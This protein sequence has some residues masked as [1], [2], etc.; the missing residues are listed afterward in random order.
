MN[1]LTEGQLIAFEELKQSDGWGIITDIVRDVIKQHC[2]LNEVNDE[3]DDKEY[4]IQCLAM[5]KAKAMF[6]QI[7]SE[8]DNIGKEIEHLKKDYS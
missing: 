1:K 4:K 3:L 8:V 2:N 5:K 6:K 7:F